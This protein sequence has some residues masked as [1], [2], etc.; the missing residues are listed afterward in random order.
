MTEHEV[1]KFLE[2]AVAGLKRKAL[3][4]IAVEARRSIVKNFEQ[5]GRP[6]PWKKSIKKKKY[7]GTK[8][9]VISGM[10]K[11]VDS[12]ANYEESSVTLT[13]NP[14]ARAYARIHQEG[15]TI[16]MPVRKLRFRDKRY[17]SGE[18]KTVFASKKHKKIKMI[19][20]A[21]A[22]T[23]TIPPRPYMVIPQ[24]DINE[25]IRKIQNS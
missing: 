25:M 11:N 7:K 15:G 5:G 12:V 8:T 22:Y 9:L 19:K 6:T 14:A 17:K 13:T 16:N 4:I 20:E 10:L 2:D 1:K 23:I 24:E 3:N 18:V 21:R